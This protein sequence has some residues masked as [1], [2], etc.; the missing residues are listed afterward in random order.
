MAR[1]VFFFKPMMALPLREKPER[2]AADKGERG[3]DKHGMQGELPFAG[4][5]RKMPGRMCI[6]MPHVILQP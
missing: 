4:T 2:N 1:K 6:E 3:R 5:S